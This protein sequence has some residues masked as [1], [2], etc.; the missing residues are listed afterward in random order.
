MPKPKKEKRWD[1]ESPSR[2]PNK[3]VPVLWKQSSQDTWPWPCG[4]CAQGVRRI[5][6]L[7]TWGKARSANRARPTRPTRLSAVITSHRLLTQRS[8]ND[9]SDKNKALRSTQVVSRGEK[10]DDAT[11]PRATTP[12]AV[13]SQRFPLRCASK[14]ESRISR[15]STSLIQLRLGWI[16]C[17][18]WWRS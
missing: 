8:S 12:T 17:S 2:S 5:P 18:I 9:E 14:I 1:Y 4:R 11:I 10:A 3:Q 6:K 16:S 15:S 7:I 13:R